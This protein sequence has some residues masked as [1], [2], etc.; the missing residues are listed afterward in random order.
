MDN[1]NLFESSINR[2]HRHTQDYDI[3]CIS[4][5]RN[6][7]VNATKY[8]NDDRPQS[9]KDE[10]TTE[11]ERENNPYEYSFEENKERNRDLKAFLLQKG[12]GVTR[13]DGS[14]IENYGKENAERKDE[15]SFFVVNL[16]DDPDFYDVLFFQSEYY[17]QDCF[18]YK[19]KGEEKGVL[20]GTNNHKFPG[21][22]KKVIQGKFRANIDVEFFSGLKNKTFA[23]YDGKAKNKDSR[24]PFSTL[25]RKGNNVSES[26]SLDTINKETRTARMAISSI[27]RPIMEAYE[28]YKTEQMIS[29]AKERFYKLYE[30][31]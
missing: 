12:Y 25:K 31:L 26:I 19:P 11:D 2:V 23:F 17:G 9:Y 22:N 8:T 20:I 7:Y 6:E 18:L 28:R 24:K 16:N 15:E 4:A 21:Y 27:V 5:F 13:I 1:S 29:E 10:F 30:Q 3:A 14:F